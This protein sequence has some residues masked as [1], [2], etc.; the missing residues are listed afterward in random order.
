MP[1]GDD[2]L[3]FDLSDNRVKMRF[4]PKDSKS[5]QITL[6][7]QSPKIKSSKNTTYPSGK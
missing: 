2:N 4:Q 3:G 6:L 5:K 1:D 7:C